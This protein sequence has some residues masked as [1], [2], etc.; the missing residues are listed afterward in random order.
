M[1]ALAG[2]ALLHLT[3]VR[4]QRQP[5]FRFLCAFPVGAMAFWLLLQLGT[6]LVFIASPWPLCGLALLS[7][8]ACEGIV[9]IYYHE[10]MLCRPRLRRTMLLLRLAAVATVC[11]MLVQPVLQREKARRIRRRVVVLVDDSLSMHRP[12]TCWTASEQL[13][14]AQALG[15]LPAAQ[16]PLRSAAATNQIIRARLAYWI[17]R[18]AAPETAE[19][20]T[21]HEMLDAD[22]TAAARWVADLGKR[23]D[24]VPIPVPLPQSLLANRA[25]LASF[26]HL[27]TNQVVSALNA[28]A[29]SRPDATAKS[30]MNAPPRDVKADLES[31]RA[32]I[33]AL[34]ANLPDAHR[35]ADALLQ[36]SFDA[37][38]RH[39]ISN[40]CAFSRVELARNMLAGNP[41]KNIPSLA[42][43][44][45]SRYD[46]DFYL[47]AGAPHRIVDPKSWFDTSD[48][49]TTNVTPTVA[50]ERAETDI[51]RALEKLIQE[52]PSEERAGMLLLTD[53]RHTGDTG[54]EAVAHVLGQTRTPVSTILIGGTEAP[55]D[56][57][58]ASVRARE[59]VFLGDRVRVNAVIAAT[60][61][62][63]VK[64]QVA[65]LREGKTVAT[66]DIAIQGVD[67]QEEI[68]LEDL[69]EERGTY[70]YELKIESDPCEILHENNTWSMDIAVSD[71]RTHV[72]LAD[73]RPRWEF[74]YLRNLFYGRDKSIHLQYFLSEPDM[75]RGLAPKK[76]VPPASASREFGDAE[77][78]A[79][80]ASLE[81]WRK[82][83]VIILG[84]LDEQVLDDAAIKAIRHCV[85]TRGATLICIAGPRSMPFAVR[86]P[87][88]QAMLPVVGS[89]TN[90]FATPSQT[91]FRVA[92]TSTG[93]S[94]EIM[95]LSTSQ[96]ENDARWNAQPPWRWRLPVDAVKPGAEILAVAA[97][98]EPGADSTFTLDAATAA[99]PE[100]A[101]AAFAER[102]REDMRRALVVTQ[103]YG[104]GKVLVLLT[105]QTWRLRYQVGD[106]HHH[107]FWGQ[108]MRWASGEQLR[109]GNAYARI[110]T[111][112][113]AYAAGEPVRIRAR[114]ADAAFSP[115]ANLKPMA[116]LADARGNETARIELTYQEGSNGLYEGTLQQQLNPGAH[117]V[118]LDVPGL[119]R[120]LGENVP[121]SLDCSFSVLT[122][123]QPKEAA[124]VTAD[125]RIPRVLTT[126]SGGRVVSPVE[127]GI[128]ESD[129]GE[130]SR[131]VVETLEIP[132]WSSPWL[133]VIILAALTTEWLLRK[134][135]GLT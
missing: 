35:A 130:P 13:D 135:G 24:T 64:T 55:F 15:V 6:R 86:N 85:E 25:R 9:W 95:S 69:P 100:A 93:R 17:E 125:E 82:F 22:A 118:K 12:D 91:E 48:A 56:F 127:A 71:N 60:S 20:V 115:L 39:A 68:R 70:R 90:A 120:I 43:R 107:R 16:R 104:A 97:P 98:N 129:F 40:A 96:M 26:Q 33:D 57:A 31:A 53:G 5:D 119:D 121:D 41:D 38:T 134:K 73:R 111:D 3:F 94:H 78:S 23:L 28:L 88:F 10:R 37:A 79:L 27:L 63:G 62:N 30:T 18:L 7:A 113:V 122:A 74:R 47:F 114:L 34:H 1:L 83:D 67:W 80:P 89:T 44:L 103:P 49:A 52:I 21:R 133:F 128:L 92:M 132:L 123:R 77:S 105:D 19:T 51:T 42:E 102:R 116:T 59:S 66:K 75:I 76:P 108:I 4:Q 2:W 87:L 110:G 101:V 81:E 84:D 99:S 14:M 117:H 46:L 109:A 112:R 29:G 8:A 126:Q 65:L 54:V 32:A 58:I 106:T 45:G 131:I 36:A 50:A 72:L 11:L 124:H 61:A